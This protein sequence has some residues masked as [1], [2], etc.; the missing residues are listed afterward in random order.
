MPKD[1]SQGPVVNLN[2]QCIYTEDT[3][4]NGRGAV[5]ERPPD[6]GRRFHGVHRPGHHSTC[7]PQLWE[8]AEILC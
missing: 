1:G 5:G 4:K 7:Q 8:I 2:P 6:D 3:L